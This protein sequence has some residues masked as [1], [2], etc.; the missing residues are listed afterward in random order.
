MNSVSAQ[1]LSPVSSLDDQVIKLWRHSLRPN[2][3][4]AYTT[5]VRQ[6]QA[7]RACA[8]AQ[9]TLADLQDWSAS[10][11]HQAHGTRKA[12]L[13]AVRSLLSY[14][15]R[16]GYIPLNPGVAMRAEKPVATTVE[17]ILT[18]AQVTRMI[19]AEPDARLRALLRLLYVCGLRVSEACDLRW[20]DMR[21]NDRKGGEIQ[22]FGKGAK[23]RAVGMPADLWRE[24]AALSPTIVPDR[25]VVPGRDGGAMTSRAA[26][27]AVKSAGRRIGVPEVSPHWL[28]HSHASHALDNGCKLHVL[29]ASLGHASVQTTSG[30]LHLKPGDSSASFIKG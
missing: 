1:A 16:M 19:A 20:R 24:L 25:P 7:F 11:A 8:L 27:R 23:I 26:H 30:Y 5:S 13:A 29:Q 9:V 17:R 28:R 22:V 21:G 3:V 2:T 14:T 18:H 12:R 4:T 6:F 15:T 10:M